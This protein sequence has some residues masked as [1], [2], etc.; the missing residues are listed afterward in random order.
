MHDGMLFTLVTPMAPTFSPN[1][2][3]PLP[4]PQ[5]PASTVPRP[6]V[7]MPL[8]MALNGGGGAPKHHRHCKA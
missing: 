4:L 2:L 1:V 8:L 7:P 6:S 5:R 3:V